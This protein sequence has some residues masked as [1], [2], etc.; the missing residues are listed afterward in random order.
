M[1][2]SL[3][4]SAKETCKWWEALG[5]S[6][7]ENERMQTWPRADCVACGLRALLSTV[8]PQAMEL[9]QGP[10]AKYLCQGP[11]REQREFSIP[12]LSD[13]FCLRPP[14]NDRLPEAWHSC[15]ITT[16]PALSSPPCPRALHE[17]PTVQMRL[18]AHTWPTLIPSSVWTNPSWYW[19]Y[20]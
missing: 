11:G 7:A 6:W 19:R 18:P 14:R 20:C 15:P 13:S 16:S 3:G 9:I 1:K 8:I 2:K 17:L 4:D 10:T 12:L 5:N